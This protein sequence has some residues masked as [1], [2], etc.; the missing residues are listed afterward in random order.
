MPVA[1]A[2]TPGAFASPPVSFLEVLLQD[3]V[4]A[5]EEEMETL[6]GLGSFAAAAAQAVPLIQ[7]PYELAISDVK[8]DVKPAAV[9]PEVQTT[10]RTFNTFDNIF[11]N[12]L[13]HQIFSKRM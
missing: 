1:A 2:G 10:V 11:V 13:M 5:V 3:A 7:E 6:T 9:I 4:H 8:E 12:F